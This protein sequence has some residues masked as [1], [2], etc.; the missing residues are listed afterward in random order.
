MDQHEAIENHVATDAEAVSSAYVPTFE[1]TEGQPPPI[2]A[3]GGVSY[4]SFERGGDA[5]TGAALDAAFKQI[6]DGQARAFVEEL[7]NAPP[8]PIQTKWGSGSGSTRNA[9][10]TFRRTGSKPPRAAWRYR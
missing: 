5:G 6:A 1:L 3:N 10:T 7:G 9:W 4:M 8:G 2:A